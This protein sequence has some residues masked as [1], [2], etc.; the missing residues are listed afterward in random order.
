VQVAACCEDQWFFYHLCMAQTHV[1]PVRRS[2]YHFSEAFGSEPEIPYVMG[3]LLQSTTTLFESINLHILLHCSSLVICKNDHIE[4]LILLMSGSCTHRFAV[5]SRAILNLNLTSPHHIFSSPFQLVVS[6]VSPFEHLQNQ[7]SS[8]S[9]HIFPPIATRTPNSLSKQP[10]YRL[11]LDLTP[12]II[13][14]PVQVALVLQQ[15]FELT[16]LNIDRLLAFPAVRHVLH[17]RGKL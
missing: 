13:D 1:L 10:H 15:L 11:A 8:R 7:I 14:R 5:S 4:E 12:P 16:V 2:F 9:P 3:M 17:A 6:I